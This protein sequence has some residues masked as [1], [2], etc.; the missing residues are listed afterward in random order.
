MMAIIPLINTH[1]YMI[2]DTFRHQCTEWWG[3]C[4][5]MSTDFSRL[6]R[7]ACN[8]AYANKT[9]GDDYY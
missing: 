7:R 1:A 8:N 2:T 6:V 5:N 3:I 9:A 4:C